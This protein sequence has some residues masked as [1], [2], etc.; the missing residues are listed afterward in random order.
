MK[1]IYIILSFTGTALSRVIKLTTRAEFAHVSI[2][3][4]KDL[5][6]MYSFGRLNPYNPFVGGFVHEGIDFG[7]FKRFEKTTR[8]N[9]Y[10]LEITD[11]QYYKLKR[12]IKFINKYKDKYRFNIMGLLFARFRLNLNRKNCYYCAEFVKG[13]L[14]AA[15][16]ENNLPKCIRP[17]DFKYLDNTSLLFEGM[18]RDYGKE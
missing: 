18:L 14:D 7:T 10:A 9:I 2:A 16:I 11:S 15:E 8:T 12:K 4:D 3:L 6:Q 13:V 5:N 17:E 1:K